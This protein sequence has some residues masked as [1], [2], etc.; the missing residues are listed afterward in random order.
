[1][2]G[3][4]KRALWLPRVTQAGRMRR[5]EAACG[6][7]PAP[8]EVARLGDREATGAGDRA[9]PGRSPATRWVTGGEKNLEM[10]NIWDLGK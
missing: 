1:M 5:R 8:R 9:T 3:G 4:T 10:H 2:V 6:T 7:A